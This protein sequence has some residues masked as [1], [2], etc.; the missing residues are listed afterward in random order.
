M[1]T[2]PK[3]P[4]EE[5]GSAGRPPRPALDQTFLGVAPALP[6]PAA[7]PGKPAAPGG[8]SAI[9]AAPITSKRTLTAGATMSGCPTSRTGLSVR[10]AAAAVP[11]C[12]RSFA[13]RRAG[14]RLAQH[15]VCDV[16]Q[17]FP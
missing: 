12:G 3:G 10:S 7:S 4:K 5:A 8:G 11:T 15:G 17:A 14:A 13:G 6:V 16:R 2:T 1:S 9:I